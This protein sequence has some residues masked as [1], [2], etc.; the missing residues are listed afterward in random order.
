MLID[1]ASYGAED[2]ASTEDE[3]VTITLELHETAGFSA[4][5]S[6]NLRVETLE[7]VLLSNQT[8]AVPELT[9][10]QRNVSATFVGLP[11]G[12]SL[13]TAEVV[14]DVGGNTSTHVSSITRTMQRLS[15]IHI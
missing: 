10:E 15:L 2:H 7:G 6:L 3:N 9:Y 5:V 8:N 4:N 11:Y 13:L 14:G 12:Y 1:V